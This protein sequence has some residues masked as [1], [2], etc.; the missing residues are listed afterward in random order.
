MRL[1]RQPRAR[2]Y[3][4]S[5]VVTRLRNCHLS[6]KRRRVVGKEL[7]TLQTAKSALDEKGGA[8]LRR[9]Q[10]E[11]GTTEEGEVELEVELEVKRKWKWKWTWNGSARYK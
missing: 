4:G 10:T 5:R 6:I 11:E 8:N 7:H 1:V 3:Q 2:R 9:G